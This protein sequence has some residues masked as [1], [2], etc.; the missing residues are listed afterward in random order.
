M[1]LVHQGSPSVQA[2][3]DRLA[4]LLIGAGVAAIVSLEL[5]APGWW[6][7]GEVTLI[8]V[9]IALAVGELRRA[10]SAAEG[11]LREARARHR[12]LLDALPHYIFSIDNDER[13]TALNAQS[14]SYFGLPEEEI[15]GHTAEELGIP[16]DVARPWHEINA[17]TRTSGKSQ[18]LDLVIP[19]DET[20]YE[21]VITQPLRNERREIVGVTGVAIDVTEKRRDEEARRR[22]DEQMSH[23]AKMESL[24]TLAGGISHDFNN[25]LSII[26]THATILDRHCSDAQLQRSIGAIRQAVDRGA[27]I[28]G[29]ILTFAQRGEVRAGAVDVARLLGDLHALV[30][31]TF[32]RTIRF[33][34]NVAPGL[35]PIAGDAG[36]LQQALLN[37]C[38]NA[39][40]AMPDGGTLSIESRLDGDRVMIAVSDEGVGLDEETRSRIFEPFFTTKD[41]SKG[42]GLGLAM[43][44]GIVR[45][46]GADIDVDSQLG[47]GTTFR[48]YFPVA[49]FP[50]LAQESEVVPAAEPARGARL[51]L[52]EDEEGILAGLEMQ[53]A[54]AGYVVQTA[55]S[56][57]EALAN[58]RDV[59]AVVLMD[60]GMPGMGAVEL[61]DALR[62]LVPGLPIVAMTG[63]VDP[64]VHDAVR[65]AGVTRIL[66]KPF[67]T[68][69]LLAAI[70]ATLRS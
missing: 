40:D 4:W 69:E 17:R 58:I 56:G 61:I 65:E 37:L 27:A 39:R 29:R 10:K 68:N 24:G 38:I 59:P 9:V 28:S 67:A 31:E 54:D 22:L 14:C 16:P 46:H 34:V 55:Q 66:Q 5:F 3:P 48:L 2:L 35:P 26:L 64:E 62:T 30:A 21:H 57:P 32:P 7:I 33:E 41:K 49:A 70:D 44:Y 8:F 23:L 52:I 11:E 42:M 25:I 43:V 15:I 12:N 47:S 13:Y 1:S 36:Q 63:Y 50:A 51:L 20:R 19:G 45:S 60:L 18:T 53:L 6:R